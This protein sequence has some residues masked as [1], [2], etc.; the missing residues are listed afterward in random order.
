MVNLV[1]LALRQIGCKVYGAAD[2]LQGLNMMRDLHPDLVLLDLMLPG[3]DG[4]Q[5]RR[6]MQADTRLTTLPV[7]LV[8]AHTQEALLSGDRKLPPAD[9][10]ITKPF[11]LAEMRSTVESVLNQR[12]QLKHAA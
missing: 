1:R 8:T 11:R 12:V 2:G 9:A 5:I 7:I 4:W 10:Y 6:A 3:S